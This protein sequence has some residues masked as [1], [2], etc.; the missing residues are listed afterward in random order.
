MD[1]YSL[2]IKT[3]DRISS[4]LK[5][6]IVSLQL[7]LTCVCVCVF[8]LS[9]VH[10]LCG[11]EKVNPTLSDALVGPKMFAL[12]YQTTD[13]RRAWV[14]RATGSG[15]N[16]RSLPQ[17]NSDFHQLRAVSDSFSFKHKLN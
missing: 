2:F 7:S 15:S 11:V 9:V 17:I 13:C 12:V 16:Y 8:G 14:R 5:G 6:A 10:Y 1:F 4:Q 3:R